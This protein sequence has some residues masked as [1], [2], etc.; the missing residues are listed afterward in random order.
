MDFTRTA[1]LHGLSRLRER[2][3][4]SQSA[5]GEGS[6]HSGA[7]F[8]ILDNPNAETAPTPALPRKREREPTANAAASSTPYAIALPHAGRG[9]GQ[10]IT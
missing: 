5:A 10:H 9:E 4:R 8:A 1:G 2:P 3:T 6:H 7:S